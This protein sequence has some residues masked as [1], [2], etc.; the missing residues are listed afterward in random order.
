MIRSFVAVALLGLSATLRAGESPPK[1]LLLDGAVSGVGVVAVGERGTIIR[2]EDGGH[3]WNSVPG[4]TTATLTAISFA[5][6]PAANIGWAVGHDAI[7]IGSTDGGKSWMK[8][9]QGESLQDSFLDVLAVDGP[10]AIAVGAYGLYVATSDGGRTWARRKLGPDD[11][12]FNRITAG[13]GTTLYL[14]GEHGTLLR[15]TDLGIKWSALQAPYEGSFYGLVSPGRSVLI[16]HGLRG[17]IFRSEDDGKTWQTIATPESNSLATMAR[18]RDGALL[19][20]GQSRSLL[21]SRDRGATFTVVPDV[22][23]AGIAR[24]LE[25]PKGHILA[26]GEAGATVIDSSR[27]TPPAGAPTPRMP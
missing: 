16:A 24:L 27:I 10:R 7:V 23:P 6:G 22:L 5:D 26:L 9:Y 8:V 1:R 18:L 20:G 14:A 4:P 3:T 12:H 2:S 17:R 11:Y 25:L 13:E 19:S 21:V 15:S